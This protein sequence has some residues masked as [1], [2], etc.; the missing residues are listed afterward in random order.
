MGG[1]G[2]EGGDWATHGAQRQMGEDGRGVGAEASGQ[3]KEFHGGD[4]EKGITGIS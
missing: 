3:R 2:R 1:P 4:L